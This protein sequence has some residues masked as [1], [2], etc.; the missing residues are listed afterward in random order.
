MDIPKSRRKPRG[1]VVGSYTEDEAEK[2]V[3]EYK[4]AARALK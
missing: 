1:V 4:S 2:W 3:A